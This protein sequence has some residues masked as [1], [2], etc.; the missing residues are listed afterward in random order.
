MLPLD[1]VIVLFLGRFVPMKGLPVRV[2]AWSHI[3][4]GGA[5]LLLVGAFA[6][7]LDDFVA[8][9]V[10]VHDWTDAPG[11]YMDSADIFV[12]PSRSE[13][14]SNALLTAMAHG[15]AVVATRV[16]AAEVMIEDGVSGCLIQPDDPAALREV[17]VSLI[18]DPARRAS[19]G[20]AA[21]RRVAERYSIGSVVDRIEAEY[22]TILGE[23]HGGG[24]S[25]S[26]C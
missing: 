4:P 5:A 15:L 26:V 8:S 22:T 18:D 25:V 1:A 17:L 13:G 21:R 24:N 10:I 23:G 3:P 20:N 11:E 14:M 9:P 12:L 2:E 16:G 19:L 7:S 6:E